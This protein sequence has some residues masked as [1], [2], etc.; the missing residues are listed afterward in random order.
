M[1]SLLRPY[2]TEAW[3]GR[4]RNGAVS[5]A[6]GACCT[7]PTSRSKTTG[8]DERTSSD[9]W[10]ETW[11]PR[12]R[13]K[14]YGISFP[15]SSF[16]S[17][18]QNSSYTNSATDYGYNQDSLVGQSVSWRAGYAGDLDS[19]GKFKLVLCYVKVLRVWF[20]RRST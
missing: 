19:N 1:S 15:P 5:L 20:T 18:L 3:P 4:H 12:I 17:P 14:K 11:S 2:M 7:L 10:T 16:R 9:T 6:A 13:L 8:S